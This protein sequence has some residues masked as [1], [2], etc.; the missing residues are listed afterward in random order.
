MLT[1]DWGEL[2]GKF[3]EFFRG[4]DFSLGWGRLDVSFGGGSESWRKRRSNVRT[5]F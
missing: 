3:L 2:N 4:A 5:L 1:W